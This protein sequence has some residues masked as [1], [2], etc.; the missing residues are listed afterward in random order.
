MNEEIL[1]EKIVEPNKNIKNLINGILFLGSLGFLII[2]ISSYLKFNIFEM[3]NA[4]EIIFFPQGITMFF[5]GIIGIFFSIN[6]FLILFFEVGEGY[7]E[8]NKKTG[9]M[10]G[11]K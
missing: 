3:L 10:T 4:N 9:M 2:G 5:Y 8:F 7:N 1:K 6:Q 11:A